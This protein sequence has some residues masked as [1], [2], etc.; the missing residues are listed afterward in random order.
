MDSGSVVWARAAKR[1]GLTATAGAVNEPVP[2]G[3]PFMASA[4]AAL[5]SGHDVAEAFY[6]AIPFNTRWNTGIFGGPLYA[7]FQTS[8]K[9]PDETPPAIERLTLLP[10]RS[11]GGGRRILVSALLATA[12]PEQADD[13]ALRQ[14]EYGVTPEYGSIVPAVEW[15]NPE[16]DTFSQ[17]RRY[18][19][20]R[21]FTYELVG[22]PTDREYYVR[23]S[24]RDPFGNVGTAAGVVTTLP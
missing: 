11:S 15:P 3:L 12:T 24:A 13:I 8:A 23:I 2:A 21:R 10:L 22:L 7:P 18:F 9:P 19:Y 5:T 14:V 1:R 16:D 4:F 20:A 6:S 17:Q